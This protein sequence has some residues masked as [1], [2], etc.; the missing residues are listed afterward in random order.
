MEIIPLSKTISSNALLGVIDDVPISKLRGSITCVRSHPQNV[1]DL[2][3][4]IRQ[5]GLL[6]P[7]I[8]RGLDHNCYEIIAGN[9]RC[10]ACRKLCWRKIT[11]HIVEIDD[12]QSFELALIENIQRETLNPIDE[13]KAFRMY[14]S[15]FGWGGVSDLAKKIGKSASYVTKR[16]SLLDLPQEVI[17]SVAELRVRPSIIQE[18]YAINDHTKQSELA[19]LI[20]RRH[21]SLRK[22][23]EIVDQ[24]NQIN[25]DCGTGSSY[26]QDRDER[27]KRVERAFDKSITA[28]KIALNRMSTVMDDLENEDWT[29][30]QVLLQHKNMVND[31]INILLKE[32]R[33]IRF[34]I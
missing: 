31:Q 30:I 12:K 18:I 19:D 24:T 4:S 22:V 32:K 20:T 6:Q 26:Y 27:V 5:T 14:V 13:A 2:A 23:R 15:E 25:Y 9:R 34:L 33:K 21:L 7:I 1:D 8:V 17:Q 28:L 3:D 11:C 29:A 10:Q 16:I